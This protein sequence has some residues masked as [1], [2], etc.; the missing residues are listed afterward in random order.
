MGEKLHE[1]SQ[2]IPGEMSRGFTDLFVCVCVCVCVCTDSEKL[3]TYLPGFS[4]TSSSCLWC[5]SDDM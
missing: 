2:K 5:D 3:P 1:V 4:A